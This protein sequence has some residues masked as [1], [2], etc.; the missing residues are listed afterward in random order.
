M[1]ENY[2]LPMVFVDIGESLDTK[3]LLLTT[4]QYFAVRKQT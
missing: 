2:Y 3:R 4:S 1:V